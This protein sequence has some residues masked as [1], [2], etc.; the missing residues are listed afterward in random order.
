MERQL[1]LCVAVTDRFQVWE[2]KRQVNGNL[3]AGWQRGYDKLFKARSFLS[4]IKLWLPFYII[5]FLGFYSSY[6]YLG[7][8]NLEAVSVYQQWHIVFV[9]VCNSTCTWREGLQLL[10]SILHENLHHCWGLL[11]WC[12]GFLG[13]L[14]VLCIGQNSLSYV[15][16]TNIPKI[17]MVY[18]E[19]LSMPR[20]CNGLNSP[21]LPVHILT[22]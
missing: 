16:I 19:L 8:L 7:N 20:V 15:S 14:L 10:E 12:L 3:S 5:F 6:F 9:C 21:C 11:M 4:K 22:S 2:Q 17:A 13:P 18:S 1:W